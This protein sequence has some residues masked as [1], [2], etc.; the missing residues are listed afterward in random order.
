M[1][2]QAAHALFDGAHTTPGTAL[3]ITEIL[4]Q[5]VVNAESGPVITTLLDGHRRTV[6]FLN[7]HCANVRAKNDQYRAALTQADLVL[8]DGIGVE[9]AAAMQGE[10]LAE[11]LNGTDIVPRLVRRAA[12]LGQSVYLLGGTPGTAQAAAARL[13]DTAPGLRIAGCR[14]GFG[15]IERT[16]EALDEINQSGA[17]I[18][19]VAMGVPLQELWI[20]RHRARLNP[21]LV[22]GVGALFD[23]LAGNVRRAPG[24]VRRVRVEWAWRLAMEPRRMARRYLIGNFE[25]LGRCVAQAL[26]GLTPSRIL[27]LTVALAAMTVLAL[28]ML[29][30]A[31]LVRLDSRGPALFRQTRVGRNGVP[32]TVYKFRSMTTDAEAQRASL[33]AQSDRAGVCFKA[34]HDPRVTRVGKVLR[35]FSL[36]ELPQVL[37]VL[38]GDMSIVGPRPALPEEVAKY[39]P[40]ALERLDVRPGIT[41][42]WQVSGRAAID[43][44]RMIDLD[45]AYVRSR[46]ALL[47]LMLIAMTVRAVVS[48]RGAY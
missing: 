40:R 46:S 37:N 1:H 22:L 15:G 6:F 43:F 5:P 9:L 3:P 45:T 7:A 21:N 27:D 47:D 4:G 39:P 23:F 16:E 42:L 17:D 25:F 28:P 18:L 11:N 13:Q 31:A 35:R 12:K 24:V 20:T 33:L 36:D 48:G 10:R 26:G 32:F 30:I 8:P 44:D 29:A 34:R 19:L 38:K 14:D 41:G 2:F